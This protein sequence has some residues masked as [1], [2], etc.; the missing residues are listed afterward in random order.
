[1]KETEIGRA[2]VGLLRTWGFDVFQEVEVAG[3]RCDLFAT[4]GPLLIAV[5]CKVR[6]TYEVIHQA[7]YWRPWAH[8]SYAAVHQV[9]RL[10]PLQVRLL[11]TVG[12][13]AFVMNDRRIRLDVEAAFTRRAE[14]Q[15]VRRALREEHRTF[16]MAGSSNAA[17]WTNFKSSVRELKT[18]L[19]AH[20]GATLKDSVAGI[21]HHYPNDRAAKSGFVHWIRAGVI[22]GIRLENERGELRLY[23][24]EEA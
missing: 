1:M 11:E 23:L 2:V 16:A 18:F 5:E 20:P 3:R 15:R 13:G 19:K 17:R 6:L 21:D 10:D 12:I 14:V 4:R 8:R 22:P 7:L 9:Y 24:T